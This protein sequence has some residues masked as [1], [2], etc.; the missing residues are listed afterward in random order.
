[1]DTCASHTDMLQGFTTEEYCLL[2]FAL[3]QC[4]NDPVY[5]FRIRPLIQKMQDR[6]KAAVFDPA[7]KEAAFGE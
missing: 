7:G 4:K 6:V 3:N 1:M 2:M 5:G